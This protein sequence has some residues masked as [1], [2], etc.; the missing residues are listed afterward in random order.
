MTMTIDIETLVADLEPVRPVSPR[1]GV[2][3]TLV[4]AAVVVAIVAAL[5]GLRPDVVAGD[6]HPARR[7]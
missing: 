7:Q 4:A 6:P 2:L 1:G 3:I 5:F